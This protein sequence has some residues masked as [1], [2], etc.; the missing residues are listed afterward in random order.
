VAEVGRELVDF[1][2][3]FDPVR[4]SLMPGEDELDVVFDAFVVE[5]R[6]NQPIQK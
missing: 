2:D 1:V 5:R 3:L 6:A 4:S